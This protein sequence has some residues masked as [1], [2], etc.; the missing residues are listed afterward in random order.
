MLGF[1]D[2]LKL[3]G[4]HKV[5]WTDLHALSHS[6]KQSL[7]ASTTYRQ[8]MSWLEVR[9]G[10]LELPDTLRT[11]RRTDSQYLHCITVII[12]IC[13]GM[14]VTAQGKSETNNGKASIWRWTYSTISHMQWRAAFFPK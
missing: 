6:Y 10:S 8:Q 14:K 9:G 1:F 4:I 3:L 5:M 13:M 11:T 7:P 12:T 2:I